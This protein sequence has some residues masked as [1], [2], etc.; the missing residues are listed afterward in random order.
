MNKKE[1]YI[2]LMLVSLWYMP[3][4]YIISSFGIF[5][6]IS[7][8]TYKRLYKKFESDEVL[9][10]F[11]TSP[12]DDQI[13]EFFKKE[14]KYNILF[15][16]I[17]IKIFKHILISKS[18]KDNN[19][20]QNKCYVLYN[21][22]EITKENVKRRYKELVKEYHPDKHPDASQEEIKEL[23]DMFNKITSCRDYLLGTI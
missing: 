4:I 15:R 20:D 7:I 1:W 14:Y 12:G 19:I 10:F 8:L 18:L 11:N 17:S 3:W 22:K 2:F 16:K 23:T 21:L 6:G 5:G 9:D 13:E